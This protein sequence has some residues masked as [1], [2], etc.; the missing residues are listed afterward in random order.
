MKKPQ[1]LRKS[2]IK[3]N[4]LIS[5]IPLLFIALFIL[6]FMLQDKK[7]EFIL[8]TD[9]LSRGIRSQIQLFL[10]QP[11]ATL[12]M[13]SKRLDRPSATNGNNITNLL[14]NYL[15][16]SGYFES[17]YLL[18]ATGKVINAGLPA[19]RERYRR[20][21]LGIEMGHKT[22]FKKVKSVGHVVWSDTFLSLA[23][24]TT[25][26]TLYMP[27]GPRVLAADINL[28]SLEHLIAQLSNASVTT[29][30][31]DR[32]GAILFHSDEKLMGKSIMMN[33]INLVAAALQGEEQTGQFSWN[34]TQYFGSTNNIATI[35]WVS[36]IAVPSTIFSSTLIIPLLIIACGICCAIGLSLLLA[37]YRAKKFAT[38]LTKVMMTSS[39]IAE[40]D[41]SHTLPT[42]DFLEL[43]QLTQSINQMVTA[44]QRREGEL[45]DNER[46][47]RELVENTSN[48]V[49]RLD[50]NLT[51]SYANHTITKLTGISVADITG[52]PLKSCISAADWPN[53]E[54]TLNHWLSSFQDS[55]N[56][57][58]TMTN[59]HGESSHLWLSVNL[60]FDATGKI[61]DF[62]IIGHDVTTRYRIEQQQKELDEKRQQSQKMELLGLMAGGV[63]HDLNNILSGIISLPEMILY[64]LAPNDPLRDPLNMVK[65]SGERAAA[66]VADLLTIAR[67]SAAVRQP[68]NINHIIENYCQAPETL[69]L[70]EIYPQVNLIITPEPNLWPCLCSKSHI[71]KTIMNLVINAFEA[72]KDH[73]EVHIST[74]NIAAK[75]I[76]NLAADLA[77]GP[78]IAIHIQ[79]SGNGIS[80][81]DIDRIFEP[82]FSKKGLGRSGTGLGLAVAW[83]SIREHNGTI[84]VKSSS[85]GTRFTILLPAQ[86]QPQIEQDRTNHAPL[87]KGNGEKILVVDDEE[88]LRKIAHEMLSLLGY[89]V[90]CAVSGEAALDILATTS[91][92]LV[93][94]DMQ[95]NP[96]INGRETYM[97]IKDLNPDQKALIVTGYST[98]NDVEKTIQ[99]GAAGFIN[100]PYSIEDLEKAI[101]QVL[102]P[103]SKV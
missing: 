1:T 50:H 23:S 43:E 26:V 36:L 51:I 42:C 25:S 97:R 64:K 6:L 59:N 71:E 11:Q 45:R 15:Q 24:G 21:I 84:L 60:H 46:K 54:K 89:Q 29:M 18:D 28:K 96:G 73:G 101:D 56:L 103:T 88:I 69:Q 31:I 82:F 92:D 33:D 22:E 20:D 90:R 7:R 62:N 95:M 37:Y 4:A 67:G 100:K 47:Y 66:V 19:Q 14:N 58:C 41:Y 81:V 53:L 86:Q 27:S 79:D 63:A 2:L 65:N 80:T 85:A 10:D 70:Q 30:V 12:S 74:Q 3:S 49:L 52:Q 75:Q 91:F 72:I 32:N 77:E 48:L 61:H 98:S 44:I 9:L 40:G 78:Y 76:G 83:N 16:E 94:L 39:I 5:L 68:N 102:N 35:G 57:E 8:R 93:L 34:G 55:G 87:K 38:P 17:I 99:A 13:I